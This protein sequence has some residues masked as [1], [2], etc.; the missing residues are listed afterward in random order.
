MPPPSLPDRLLLETSEFT[1]VVVPPTALTDGD[2]VAL[3]QMGHGAFSCV[4]QTGGWALRTGPVCGVVEL[5]GCVVTIRPRLMPD[6][7]TVASW[8]AY[9]LALPV[10]ATL[11]RGWSVAPDGLRE[12]VAAALVHEC[13]TLLRDG[14]RRDYQ[15]IAAVDT[16]LRGRL[17]ISR[18]LSRRYGQVDRLHL[19]R[20]DRVVEVWEN[21]VLRAALDEVV[22]SAADAGLRRRAAAAAGA[23]PSCTWN[24]AQVLRQLKWARHHR[25]NQRYR[26]AHVWA[27]LLLSGGGVDDLLYPGPWRAGSLLVDMT[28]LW[29]L[30]VRRLCGEA[31]A[32]P[33]VPPGQY[34]PVVE[35]GYRTRTFRPDA[36]VVTT[37]GTRVL[38][39]D[40]K[41][42]GYA[43]EAVDRDHA[44]Q[45]LT[46][47]AGYARSEHHPIALL[48]HPTTGESG[49]RRMRVSGAFG[50]LATVRVVGIRTAGDPVDAV[51]H[52]RS[53]LSPQDP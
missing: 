40:A 29:E 4:R 28:R 8:I 24:R 2:L 47:A 52:V 16:V 9:A 14:L 51:R 44:H 32:G 31:S 45:L 37:D 42:K 36:F 26:A 3:G 48:V 27:D 41:Y 5:D 23:F 19:D 33:A 46:Y 49:A 35:D 43:L 22:R 7:A 13:R 1:E 20:F 25:M 10:E 11:T 34:L 6:S 38:P 15:R 18:Q 30:V 17:D 50:R 39:V 53:Q 21:L 12:V